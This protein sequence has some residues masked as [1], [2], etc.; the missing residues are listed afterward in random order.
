MGVFENEHNKH[1]IFEYT[2]VDEDEKDTDKLSVLYVS[3]DRHNGVSAA[4]LFRIDTL[5]INGVKKIV[6]SVKDSSKLDYE[7]LYEGGKAPTYTLL[8]IVNDPD[9]NGLADTLTR[10]V[11]VLDVNEPPTLA[12]KTTKPVPEST[13]PGA[14]VDTVKAIDPDIAPEYSTLTYSLV[15]GDTA[16][17]KIDPKT[18]ELILKTTLDYEKKKEYKVVVRVTDGKY[19]DQATVTIPIA[20]VDEKSVVE[21]TKVYDT[22]N[23][24][25]N[26]D[27]V[28]THKPVREICW[29]VDGGKEKCVN[30]NIAKDSLYRVIDQGPTTNRPDTATVMIFYSNA[31]PIVT[32]EGKGESVIA[33]NIYTV[34]EKT[35]ASDENLY[36]NKKDNVVRVR[37]KD[38]ASG[39]DSTFNV[40]ISLEPVNVPQKTYDALNSVASSGLMLNL[41]PQK[42][43]TRVPLN[44][45]GTKISYKEKVDGVEVTVSYVLD[46]DGEVMKQAILTS[47]GKLDTVEVMTVSYQTEVNGKVVTVSYQANAMTGE[48]LV[49]DASGKLMQKGASKASGNKSDVSEGVFM[50]T[51]NTEDV[52]GNTTVVSYS[53][54]EKGKMIKNAGGD[55]GYEVTYSYTNKYGNAA[56][57]SVF[58]VLDQVGPKV[59]IRSPVFGQIIRSNFVNVEWYVDGIKQDTLETEGLEKGSNIIV[60][61]FRDK[62]GNEAS[63]TIKV[64]MKNGKDVDI[65][66]VKP[67]TE[68]SK[69]DVEEFYKNHPP[70]D[71]ETFAVSIVIPSDCDAKGNCREQET[72]I[73]GSVDD[74]KG[75]VDSVKHLGPT[76]GM[77]V[78]LPMVNGV[79]GLATLDDLVGSDGLIAMQGVDAENSYKITVEDYVKHYCDAGV[80]DEDISR[81]NLYDS[82]MTADIWVYS[83]IGNF[84]NKLS[85]TQELNNPDYSNDV[86]MLK[87]FVE[88]KP[89]MD[90]N[91]RA[92]NGKLLAT[93]A[94]LYKV[95]AEIKSKL[96]CD[97]PSKDFNP[98]SKKFEG[99]KAK[100]RENT[101]SIK[102]SDEL[103][104][105]FGYKRPEE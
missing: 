62:A 70:K 24:Y 6:L 98:V 90:G 85:F 41:N 1:H 51:Y 52:V 81:I 9:K 21:I 8:V 19:S 77:E 105:P 103:L 26:P 35:E 101:G 39:K 16:T 100:T 12:D 47:N 72:L 44:G 73:G 27:T 58:I 56:T 67:V 95:N 38:P 84:V 25:P 17:F 31:S 102:S 40:K 74:E 53:V 18:G 11:Q 46:N 33:D 82:K 48:V 91:V 66:V 71:G 3:S 86:G 61:I 83:T 30:V 22:D 13:L 76:L 92:K 69:D 96:R 89:D 88:M 5:T 42:G 87:M 28:Y 10:I 64:I 65:S 29:T 50:V 45:V 93:G 55:V 20:D 54:N 14:V 37:V 36:V 94:Y 97:L 68:I 2:I 60:R 23:L 15:G 43:E 104:K 59:E 63:D 79:S 80:W 49:K 78:K 75:S 99:P 4:D 7:A 34:V 32:I 57:Q